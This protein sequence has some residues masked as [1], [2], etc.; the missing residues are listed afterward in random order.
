VILCSRSERGLSQAM[1][2]AVTFCGRLYWATVATT[3]YLM[4]P[5]AV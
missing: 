4:Y 3:F 1:P 2:V 5:T